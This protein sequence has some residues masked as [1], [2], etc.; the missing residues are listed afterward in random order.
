VPP[1]PFKVLPFSF[2]AT[3]SGGLR[4][5]VNVPPTSNPA[6]TPPLLFQTTANSIPTN[7]AAGDFVLFTGLLAHQFPAPGNPGPLT[8]SF[9]TPVRGA[10]TQIAVD[11]TLNFI[12][13]ISAFDN[14][15]NLLGTFSA[16][17]TS[18]LALDNSA[19][20]LGVLSDTANIS[21]LEFNTSVTNRAI[22]INRLSVQTAAVP[23]PSS[24][25]A[26]ILIGIGLCAA[27]KSRV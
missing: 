20:F 11:D 12:A 24:I 22:G 10:G 13:S 26:P 9:E 18:S 8:L 17:G 15:N 16:P 3:S 2:T 1:Q 6:I 27:K 5:N 25:A 7:F 21:R 4:V 23:E 19:L 14:N